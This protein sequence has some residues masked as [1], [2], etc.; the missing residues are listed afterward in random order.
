MTILGKSRDGE[1]MK[2]VY[3]S[4]PVVNETLELNFGLVLFC[5][6]MGS[7]DIG[8]LFNETN[9]KGRHAKKAGYLGV[10]TGRDIVTIWHENKTH[11]QQLGKPHPL[12]TSENGDLVCK[13][14]DYILSLFLRTIWTSQL[15]L[16][17]ALWTANFATDDEGDL[18]CKAP[19]GCQ[20]QKYRE[21]EI[22]ISRLRPM[23][24]VYLLK[25]YHVSPCHACFSPYRTYQSLAWTIGFF[26]A[27][28]GAGGPGEWILVEMMGLRG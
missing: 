12:D 17:P 25:W 13:A 23:S 4:T 3:I 8:P 5:T 7:P 15:L 26:M 14:L 2:T 10:F 6:K 28:H 11:R 9:W 24:C 1:R 27:A 18:I 20:P 16:R 22:E 21:G 19:F